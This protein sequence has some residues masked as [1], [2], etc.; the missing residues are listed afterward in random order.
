MALSA[1]RRPGLSAG[2]GARMQPP[3]CDDPEGGG[4]LAVRG[5]HRASPEEEEYQ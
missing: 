2:T 1:G 5:R 3:P 4:W